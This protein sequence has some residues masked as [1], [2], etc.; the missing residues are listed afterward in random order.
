MTDNKNE[1]DFYN[2]NQSKVTTDIYFEM[3]NQ[4][5]KVYFYL[6]FKVYPKRIQNNY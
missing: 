4:L 3:P 1:S 2:P 5:E 6:L